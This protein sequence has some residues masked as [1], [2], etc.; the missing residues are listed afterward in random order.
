MKKYDFKKAIRLIEE[1]KSNLIE[2]SMGMHEDWFWTAD[3]IFENGKFVKDLDDETSIAGINS[4]SWATPTIQ[5]IF[6][7][8]SE[9][10]IPCY[11]GESTGSNPGIG[12]LGVLSGPVQE[13][14]TPL[15]EDE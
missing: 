4:S 14:I 5:L 15:S 9:K 6:S 8:E 3:T 2:A 10:M 13:N 12:L 1:N 7:D 11:E